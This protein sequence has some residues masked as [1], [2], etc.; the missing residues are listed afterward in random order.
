MPVVIEG[1]VGLRKALRNYGDTFLKE[2]DAKVRAELKPIVEDAR[3]KVPNTPPGN[4]YNWADRG[5]ERESRTGRQRAFPS[6]NANLIRKGLT[7]SL[8]K[9]RQDRTGFVSMFTLFNANAAGA[10][11]ETAGRKHPGGSPRSESNN[12]NAGRDFI[13]AMNGVGGLKDYAGQGQKTTGRLLFAA[14]LRNQGRAVGAIMKAIEE[15][16]IQ[17]GRDVAKSKRLVA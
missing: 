7:Y 1:I 6:Y 11:I 14:Y 10:I 4:L 15:A 3:S 12:P 17:V 2:Y 8:A 9:N 13:L 5:M 16:N